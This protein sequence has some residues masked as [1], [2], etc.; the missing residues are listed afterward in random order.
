MLSLVGIGLIGYWYFYFQDC[1]ADV[2]LP[3]IYRITPYYVELGGNHKKVFW[4]TSYKFRNVFVRPIWIAENGLVWSYR[5]LQKSLGEVNISPNQ[6]MIQCIQYVA[7]NDPTYAQ[8]N[9]HLILKTE[10][11][12]T[13]SSQT[14]WFLAN[15]TEFVIPNL[16]Y[17]LPTKDFFSISF[18]LYRNININQDFDLYHVQI[19]LSLYNS[20][21]EAIKS[22]EQDHQLSS[23]RMNGFLT[24]TGSANSLDS[25]YFNEGASCEYITQQGLYV[26]QVLMVK[27]PSESFEYSKNILTEDWQY[28][29][30][31]IK[32]V[33]FS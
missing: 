5:E 21:I 14:E 7:K 31:I 26:V 28:F 19:N 12:N 16:V 6:E 22:F 13:T 32:S 17:R 2:S 29:L 3:T 18:D 23:P 9:E 30:S 4:G 15:Y 24:Q 33:L 10:H 1:Q 25:C 27:A 8:R 20:E 11:F